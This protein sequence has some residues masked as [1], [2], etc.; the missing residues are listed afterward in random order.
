MLKVR[1]PLAVFAGLR[2]WRAGRR[3]SACGS[4]A[5]PTRR[6]G[7][8]WR[9]RSAPAPSSRS[10]SRSS[11]YLMRSSRRRLARPVRAEH[12]RGTRDRRRLHVRHGDAREDLIESRCGSRVDEDRKSTGRVIVNSE[13]IAEA[14]LGLG[15]R[16]T[17]RFGGGAAFSGLRQD[18]RIRI[19]DA[20][21]CCEGRYSTPFL[22]PE[23]I[24]SMAEI[25]WAPMGPKGLA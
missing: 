11:A 16:D 21:F 2:C 15:E 6:I 25:I 17:G 19:P 10:S 9:W 5:L 7:R 1:P 24:L 20:T 23:T 22:M 8:H 4:A 12:D 14:T 13:G 3:S 18:D